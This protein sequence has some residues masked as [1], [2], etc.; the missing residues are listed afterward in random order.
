MQKTVT[1]KIVALIAVVAIAIP[2][3]AAAFSGCG[4]VETPDEIA[5]N[6]PNLAADGVFEVAS[7]GEGDAAVFSFGKEIT[8]NTLVMREKGSKI[9]QF[10]LY[11]DGESEPFYSS[12]LIEDYRVCSFEPVSASEIV[13]RADSCDGGWKLDSLEAYMIDRQARDDFR[14][15]G[16]ITVDSLCA[17]P[18]QYDRGRLFQG[19][20]FDC[21]QGHLKSRRRRRS[22]LPLR[23]RKTARYGARRR[24]RRDI[25]GQQK[26]YLR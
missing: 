15:M 5:S 23:P 6:Y 26:R 3:A 21:L 16:Y 22:G 1:K 12:D 2:I 17:H 18:I 19:R 25:V 9:T 24:D 7:G 11:K 13:V 14:I 4:P 20:R 8:F 10:S